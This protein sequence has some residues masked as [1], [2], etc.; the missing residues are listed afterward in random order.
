MSDDEGN[1]KSGYRLEYSG[2]ARAKC[3]GP[4]PC[5]GTPIAK[6]ELRVGSLVDF[7]GNT[8]FAWRHW[9]CTTAKIIA[10]MK[11]QFE[12]ADELDGYDE[13]R[14]ED[15]EKVNKAW[16]DGHVADEDI[17]ETARKPEKD[18][19]SETDEEEEKEK[20]KK[21]KVTSA[22]KKKAEKEAATEDDDDAPKKKRAPAKKKAPAEKKE[23][24]PAKKRA[25]PKKKATADTE[26]SGED[27]TA[28]MDDVPEEEAEETPDEDDG[29]KKRKRPA[30]KS[31]AAKPLAKKAKASG[32][33]TKKSKAVVEDDDDE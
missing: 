26:D 25:P 20:A 15:Q 8:S 24:A 17:P 21:K 14:P 10:N 22:K 5:A 1:K 29:A 12:S 31:K 6:G 13:L 4:K 32:S 33:R 9:G 7:R 18:S 19:G 28:A 23:K 11:K 27:F 16:E 3:K 2:S 30:S